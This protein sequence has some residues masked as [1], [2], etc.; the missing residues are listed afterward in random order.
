MSFVFV[1]HINVTRFRALNIVV[2][3]LNKYF[4]IT[5]NNKYQDRKQY[6]LKVF[7]YSVI[8]IDPVIKHSISNTVAQNNSFK[9]ADFVL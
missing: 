2:R 1:S 3:K 6:V 8:Q 5:N 9:A 7:N 4:I